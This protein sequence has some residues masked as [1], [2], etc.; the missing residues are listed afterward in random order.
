VEVATDGQGALAFRT[1]GD[2]N[3]D[4]DAGVVP[5]S[6][7]DSREVWAVPYLGRVA[8]LLDSR[9]GFFG[10]V[11]IPGLVIAAGELANIIKQIGQS[12]RNSRVTHR[13]LEV[14][15]DGQGA[16]ALRTE[17]DANND[18]NA[19]VVPASSLDSR[20][21]WAVPYLGRVARPLDSRLGFFG[22]VAITGLV[23]AAGEL[24]NIIKQIGQLRRKTTV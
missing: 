2:A 7:V 4:A 24:A 10:L 20:E 8:R 1:K 22:L 9:L 5:A 13:V 17:G 12:R 18:A 6:S 14:A 21:A 11:A 3:N 19:G 23:I 16:L 15:T